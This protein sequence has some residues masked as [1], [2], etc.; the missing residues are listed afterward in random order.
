VDT[1]VYLL[2][3]AKTPSFHAIFCI[4]TFNFIRVAALLEYVEGT[5]LVL[6]N[7]VRS[8]TR[9]PNKVLDSIGST[10]QSDIGTV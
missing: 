2:R 6:L 4:L 9:V 1:A 7:M 8:G 10:Y 3:W 5:L